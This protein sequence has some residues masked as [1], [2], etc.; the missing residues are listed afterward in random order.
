MKEIL[1]SQ[2]L[3][4]VEFSF[5]EWVHRIDQNKFSINELNLWG[6]SN[7]IHV[8]ATVFNI[9][10]APQKLNSYVTGKDGIEW[11][12]SGSVFVGSGITEKGV[13]F[14]YS[15]DWLSAGRWSITF[16]TKDGSY[17]LSPME[18]LTFCPKGTIQEIEIIENWSGNIKCGFEKMLENWINEEKDALISISDLK[19]YVEIIENIFKYEK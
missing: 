15:S 9:I 19:D 3:T 12:P 8:I 16:R 10:G 2:E 17:Q 1:E 11:H 4:S 13:S 7:C 14:S 18:A 6:V 5:T